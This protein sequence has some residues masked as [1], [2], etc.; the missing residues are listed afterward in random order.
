M[1]NYSLITYK[2]KLVYRGGLACFSW[3]SLH[4]LETGPQMTFPTKF[5]H[6]DLMFPTTFIY[7][8]IAHCLFQHLEWHLLICFYAETEQWDHSISSSNLVSQ[9]CDR[10]RRWKTAQ[11][12]LQPRPSESIC[13][14]MW[15]LL[16]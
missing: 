7:S 11:P 10:E 8:V 1:A 2:L 4:C 12:L 16:S 6:I 5:V 9:E 13:C 3:A 15:C 14:I